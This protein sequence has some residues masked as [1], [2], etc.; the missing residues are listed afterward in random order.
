[1]V[2]MEPI[3]DR[4]AVS[5]LGKVPPTQQSVGIVLDN[6]EGRI[7]LHEVLRQKIHHGSGVPTDR[8][9]SM[10]FGGGIDVDEP[11]S[12]G[13]QKPANRANH[14]VNWWSLSSVEWTRHRYQAPPSSVESEPVLPCQDIAAGQDRGVGFR[15]G[16][17][18]FSD[19]G[20][21]VRPRPQLFHCCCRTQNLSVGVM[22]A[23]KLESDWSDIGGEPCGD[24]DRRGGHHVEGIGEQPLKQLT[25]QGLVF[26]PVRC[27]LFKRECG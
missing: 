7:R 12:Q 17:L 19:F 13:M 25:A 4:G 8:N 21:P 18:R 11:D 3:P 24:S 10:D 26:Q 23:C 22:T 15:F 16:L 2:W 6:L 27:E 20:T 9:W 14:T 1:A 5:I